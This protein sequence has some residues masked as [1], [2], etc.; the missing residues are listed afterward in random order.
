MPSKLTEVQKQAIPKM[1]KLGMSDEEI[2]EL[3]EV[4]RVTVWFYTNPDKVQEQARRAKQFIR[5]R[6]LGTS[7]NGKPKVINLPV[8]KRQRPELCEICHQAP[9]KW[10]YHHW[11]NRFPWLGIWVCWRCHQLVELIDKFGPEEVHKMVTA[12]LSLKEGVM[13]GYCD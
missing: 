9:K 13:E 6:Q 11:D 2:A 12:Y 1:K 5:Y 10:N 7:V 3:L 4:H 8:S